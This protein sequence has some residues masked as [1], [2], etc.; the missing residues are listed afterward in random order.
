MDSQQCTIQCPNCR[1]IR[2]PINSQ[3]LYLLPATAYN[4]VDV[5]DYI[6]LANQARCYIAATEE[7]MEQ[8]PVSEH[9][10][11]S[12]YSAAT[13]ELMEQRPA[14]SRWA[15]PNR[16][17][18]LTEDDDD[19]PAQPFNTVADKSEQP[20]RGTSIN[21]SAVLIDPE[22]DSDE[23]DLSAPA[24]NEVVE[25]HQAAIAEQSTVIER[26]EPF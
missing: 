1:P 23:Y 12:T 3:G 11:P 20:L 25:C 5:D 15:S 6:D 7:L 22:V 18:A 4:T 14:T 21:R 9:I 24:T 16:F 10:G 2:C 26:S 17:A 13:E 8:R 19:E